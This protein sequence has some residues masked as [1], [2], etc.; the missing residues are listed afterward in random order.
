[1]DHFA[2]LNRHCVLFGVG[3]RREDRDLVSHRLLCDMRS[4]HV[5]FVMVHIL[6]SVGHLVR[7]LDRVVF[8]YV[9][10]ASLCAIDGLGLGRCLWGTS[11]CWVAA[12]TSC[13]TLTSALLLIAGAAGLELD[14]YFYLSGNLD[15]FSVPLHTSTLFIAEHC[16][17]LR[18]GFVTGLYNLMA[19]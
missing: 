3:G 15:C 8:W 9:F 4:G 7:R 17:V 13:L 6:H 10:Y 11:A 2:I 18:L 12:S 1:M 16:L 19:P 5:D 14:L